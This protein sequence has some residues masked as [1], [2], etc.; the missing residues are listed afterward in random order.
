[1]SRLEVDMMGLLLRLLLQLQM[2]TE[3]WRKKFKRNKVLF[4]K[5]LQNVKATNS[6]WIP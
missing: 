6:A 1:M 3:I 2:D 5:P 4:S